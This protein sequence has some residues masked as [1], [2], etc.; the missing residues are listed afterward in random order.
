VEETR[1]AVYVEFLIAFLPV[2]TFFLCL[3]QLSLLFAVKLGVEHAAQV[4][5]RG[6]AVVIGDEPS[7][8]NEQQS[9][10]NT[11]TDKRKSAITDAAYI[12]LAPFI[13]D[14]SIEGIDVL[15]PKP[16][17]P[18]GE[19]QSGG[20]IT[21]PPMPLNGASMVRVRLEV[22]VGCRIAFAN[23][24]ICGN[25]LTGLLGNTPIGALLPPTKTVRAEAVYP[26]QGA[27]Y[28]YK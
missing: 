7:T 23:Q 1:G 5:A 11:L 13:L 12:A 16:D 3:L 20:K 10:V 15:F 21:Y 14:G 17:A 2:L 19:D 27:R 6:A 18:G 24:I 4:C 25:L 26:Y 28:E 8:Y 9:D 22:K